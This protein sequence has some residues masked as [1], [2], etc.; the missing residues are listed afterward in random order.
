MKKTLDRIRIQPAVSKAQRNVENRL[1]KRRNRFAEHFTFGKTCFLWLLMG[2]V[3][4]TVGQ[5]ANTFFNGVEAV[6][7]FSLPLCFGMMLPRLLR[8]DQR[9]QLN[10]GSTTLLGTQVRVDVPRIAPIEEIFVVVNV[11]TGATAPGTLTAAG[12]LNI[13]KRVVIIVNDGLGQRNLVDFSGEGLLEYAQQVGINLDGATLQAVADQQSMQG[14]RASQKYQITYRIPMV[15]PLITEPL[16]T[17]MLLPVQNHV[18]DPQIVLDFS[19]AAD[20]YGAGSLSAVIADIVFARRD[21]APSINQSI[22]GNGGY[23]DWDL[24]ETPFQLGAGV[25]GE[26]RFSIPTPGWYGNLLL[27]HFKGGATVTRGDISETTTVGSET[28]W[29]IVQGTK[30]FW[31]WRNRHVALI[32]DLSRTT[33]PY[34]AR[35][36][37]LTDSTGGAVSDTIANTAGANPTTA[38]FENAVASIVAK[39]NWA[40]GQLTGIQVRIGEKASTANNWQDPSSLLLDFLTDLQGSEANELGSVL[41]C[42]NPQ[43]LGE[44]VEIVAPVSNASTNGHT[45]YVG[46]LRFRSDVRKFMTFK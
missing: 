29:K 25:S 19:A 39:M 46:G 15:H 20:M 30:T 32:N 11:T 37:L 23:V 13:L 40:I 4:V 17:R 42:Q 28:T 45:L 18:S 1:A 16:R 5:C 33:L 6:S 7:T 31:E 21:M 36:A 8:F 3:A 2:L 9:Q 44:K 26:Q 12:L 41:D 22:Q 38:E 10:P 43:A 24:I 14:F 27:R 34:P 35:I